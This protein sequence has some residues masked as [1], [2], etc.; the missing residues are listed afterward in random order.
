MADIE[1]FYG[2]ETALDEFDNS[3]ILDYVLEN[4]PFDTDP[5]KV[6]RGAVFCKFTHW[7]MKNRMIPAWAKEMQEIEEEEANFEPSPKDSQISDY[8]IF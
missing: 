5:I 1:A 7:M 6:E 8:R 4:D 3:L 2:P